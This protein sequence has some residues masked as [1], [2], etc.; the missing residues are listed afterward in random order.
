MGVLAGY[1]YFVDKRSSRI[2]RLDLN[3]SDDS[4]KIFG[5]N[6]FYNITSMV[7]F[8]ESHFNL[9]KGKTNLQGFLYYC[10][11][12]CDDYRKTVSSQENLQE[13]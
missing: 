13:Y 10:Y 1:F 7:L 6:D 11:Y 3:G 9:K 2:H 12:C 5:P 8:G 4:L